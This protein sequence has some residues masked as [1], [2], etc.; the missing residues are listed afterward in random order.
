M[1]SCTICNYITRTYHNFKK[2]LKTQKHLNLEKHLNL[3]K[4]RNLEKQLKIVVIIF[5]CTYCDR[6]Y[7]YKSNLNRHLK[8]CQKRD[9]KTCQK[10]DLNNIKAIYEQ[11]LEIEKLKYQN[12]ELQ[13]EIKKTNKKNNKLNNEITTYQI[14]LEYEKFV[15]DYIKN[16]YKTCYLWNDIPIGIL[17][18]KFYKNCKIFDDIGCDIIG[19]N[20][21]DTI[22]YIQC[23]NYSNTISISDLSGFYN[24]VSENSISNSIVYYNGKLSRQVLLRKYNIQYINLPFD[25]M[26]SNKNLTIDTNQ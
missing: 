3:L 5:R 17:S 12:L 7:S 1:H 26:S 4:H 15:L 24:F 22:D 16:K 9:L 14:G 25:I 10:R 13:I 2:H 20:H 18:D 23:K 8:T 19:I 11:Q 6:I 21:D